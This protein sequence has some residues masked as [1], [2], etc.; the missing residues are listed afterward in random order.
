LDVWLHQYIGPQQATVLCLLKHG[1]GKC[2]VCETY[3][4]GEARGKDYDELREFAAVRR[5][6][7]WFL[8]RKKEQENPNQNCVEAWALPWKFDRDVSAIC[9]DPITGELYQIDHPDMGFDLSFVKEGDQDRTTYGGAQLARRSTSVDD[10]WLDYVL[11]NPLPDMLI[12]RSYEEV[13]VLLGGAP[14]EQPQP[15]SAPPVQT[16]DQGL[17]GVAGDQAAPA[18]SIP[19]QAPAP[20]PAPTPAPVQV[21]VAAPAPAPQFCEKKVAAAGHWIGCIYEFGHA[22]LCDFQRDLGVAPAAPVPT[23]ATAPFPQPAT[24]GQ[25]TQAALSTGAPAAVQSSSAQPV[26]AAAVDV[27]SRAAAFRSRLNNQ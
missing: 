9:K 27:Q 20:A 4:A 19:Q 25:S 16:M 17:F 3:A 26:Q 22:G 10:K 1:K 6:L 21:P 24:L 2:P 11:A 15:Q 13:E 14:T 8:N 18:Q 7:V 5:V 12:W 23:P